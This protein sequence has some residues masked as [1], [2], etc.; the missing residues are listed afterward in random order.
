MFITLGVGGIYLRSFYWL[1]PCF[2]FSNKN[3]HTT[4][5]L[6]EHHELVFSQSVSQMQ[7][8]WWDKPSS[9]VKNVKQNNYNINSSVFLWPKFSDELVLKKHANLHI[10]HFWTELWSFQHVNT[11]ILNLK[12]WTLNLENA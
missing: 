11:Y 4:L 6:T 8:A 5:T 9:W 12:C 2:F 10:L 7:R 3:L 1:I